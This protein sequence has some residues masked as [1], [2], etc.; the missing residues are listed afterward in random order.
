MPSVNFPSVNI[1]QTVTITIPSTI[2]TILGP[3][4]VGIFLNWG[5]LGLLMNQIYVYYLCF[6]NDS[7][8]IKAI[9]YTVLAL[10]I[11]QTCML[12]SDSWKW[13]ISAWGHPDQLDEYHLSWFDIPICGG[14][15]SGI[16]QL[17]FA[18]RIWLL[19]KSWLLPCL[20]TLISLLQSAAAIASGIQLRHLPSF[21][22][23][24]RLSSPILVW[25]APEVWH[26]GGTSVDIIIATTMTYLLRRTKGSYDRTDYII[27]QLVKMTVETGTVTAA[28][29]IIDLVLF[30]LFKDNNLHVAPAII[31]GKLYSNTLMAIFNNRMYLQ[32]ASPA[33]IYSKENPHLGDAIAVKNIKAQETNLSF[34]GSFMEPTPR[35]DIASEHVKFPSDK[36]MNASVQKKPSAPMGFIERRQAYM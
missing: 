2:P 35:Q 24:G 28:V 20:I 22:Q 17:T 13:F 3:L 32:R 12:S 21:A 4:L 8:Y 15:M 25:H 30:L 36:P 1:D 11:A 29:S 5:L 6:P 33:S 10:E 18:W 7:R 26:I 14:I 9:V 16:V 19:S 23:I 27:E 31:L 34:V